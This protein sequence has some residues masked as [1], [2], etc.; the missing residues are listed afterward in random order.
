MTGERTLE[1]A[2]ALELRAPIASG[3]ETPPRVP[4]LM[5]HPARG[6]T[7]PRGVSPFDGDLQ[8]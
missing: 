3:D 1:A 6:F 2:R 8:R 4:R 5:L 7:L